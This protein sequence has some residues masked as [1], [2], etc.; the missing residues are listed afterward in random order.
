[1]NGKKTLALVLMSVLLLAAMFPVAAQ[2]SDMSAEAAPL[3]ASSD[4]FVTPYFRV[5]VRSGPGIT[6]TVIGLVTP[7]DT[8]DITGQ[9]EAGTWLR[10][11][12]SGQEGW[13]F[14]DLMDVSGDLEAAP[15]VEAG[16]SAVLQSSVTP[17]P[18]EM[19]MSMTEEPAAL[20]VLTY[21]NTNL[22]DSYTSDANVLATIPYDTVLDVQGRTDDSNWLMVTFEDQSGWVYAPIL[23]FA[24]GDVETLPVLATVP[25]MAEETAAAQ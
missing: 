22:R 9:N 24:S 18:A 4:L 2:D 16:D 10:L 19:D 17:V 25:M 15:V 7:A 21:Y 8:L 3:T 23:N 20:E 11:N 6:Y 1:M 14:G 13:V 12:F 5:N